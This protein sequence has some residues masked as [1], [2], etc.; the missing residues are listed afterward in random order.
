[1]RQHI[2]VDKTPAELHQQE[3]NPVIL[4]A[5]RLG[6]S[7]A[8]RPRSKLHA[9]PTSKKTLV[10]LSSVRPDDPGVNSHSETVFGGHTLEPDLPA[11]SLQFL[12]S[13][14]S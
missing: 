11:N 2:E 1:M 14:L 8:E 4:V 5:A 13:Q 6:S 10:D 3:L 7:H 12:G 9:R